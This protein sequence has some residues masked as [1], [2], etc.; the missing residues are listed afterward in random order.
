MDSLLISALYTTA[1]IYCNGVPTH[2]D[3]WAGL[4]IVPV[5]SCTIGDEVPNF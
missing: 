5:D 4:S 3:V 1:S 2:V